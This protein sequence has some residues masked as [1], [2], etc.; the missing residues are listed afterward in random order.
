ML[1]MF[2]LNLFFRFGNTAEDCEIA[3]LQIMLNRLCL[4]GLDTWEKNTK[5]QVFN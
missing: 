5:K 2:N 3:K 4:I 1:E